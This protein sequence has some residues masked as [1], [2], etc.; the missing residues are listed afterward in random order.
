MDPKPGPVEADYS[1]LSDNDDPIYEVELLVG[2]RQYRGKTQYLVKWKDYGHE[3][4]E[5]KY[6]SELRHCQELVDAYERRADRGIQS[7][8][9]P[10]G[11]AAKT[12][13]ASAPVTHDDPATTS[14]RRSP[15]IRKAPK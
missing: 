5:W 10:R 15:R 14:L 13:Q 2:R 8:S 1:D 11:R 6:A 9:A 3:D 4:N 12:P 7:A